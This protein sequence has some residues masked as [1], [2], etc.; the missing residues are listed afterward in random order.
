M[1]EDEVKMSNT[2]IFDL[3]NTITI[4]SNLPYEKKKPNIKL[5]KKI[6]EYHLQ[7]FKIVI[8]TSRNMRTFEGNLEQIRLKTLPAIIE[9]LDSNNVYY[10]DI[11]IGKPWCGYGG[12]Y[13]DDRSIR[14]N[15]FIEN[16]YEDII[17]LI[18]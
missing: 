7:G 6:K 13:I 2:L 12:F 4:E 3:D 10:D 11:I 18:G 8:M 16:E 5:I 15:E 17:K 1:V 9:W 14:P